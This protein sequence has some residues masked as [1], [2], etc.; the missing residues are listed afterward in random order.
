MFEQ[1]FKN[2]DDTQ[3]NFGVVMNI[4]IPKP[5]KRER[6]DDDRAKYTHDLEVVLN[7]HQKELRKETNSS[8]NLLFAWF[9]RLTNKPELFWLDQ[10]QDIKLQGY[11]IT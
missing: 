11:V 1:T 3:F 5:P 7:K 6:T 4:G 8:K 2:V 10:E 9:N